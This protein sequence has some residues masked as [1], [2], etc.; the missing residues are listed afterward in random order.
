M[1]EQ[2]SKF[3]KLELFEL[4]KVGNEMEKPTK[5]QGSLPTNCD[6]CKCEL[7]SHPF[8]VDGL[9]TKVKASNGDPGW[10]F[11]CPECFSAYGVGLGLA[12]GQKFSVKTRELIEGGEIALHH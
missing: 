5:W 7:E 1:A 12:K 8:F 4:L 6:L 9:S 2:D 10:C 3:E 11:M